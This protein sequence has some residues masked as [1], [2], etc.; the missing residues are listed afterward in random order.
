[1]M[2]SLFFQ[3]GEMLPH[4]ITQSPP[5]A[6]W[7]LAERTWQV[8]HGYNPHI[9]LCCSTQNL[10]CKVWIFLFSIRLYQVDFTKKTLHGFKNVPVFKCENKTMLSHT[11]TQQGSPKIYQYLTPASP[12]SSS[13]QT[14]S[15]VCSNSLLCNSDQTAASS[16]TGHPET[17][18]PPRA[19]T[20]HQL[21]LL[22][23]TVVVSAPKTTEHS[24]FCDARCPL[25]D[26]NTCQ[27]LRKGVK[28]Q[29]LGI[30]YPVT[31]AMTHF[32]FTMRKQFYSIDCVSMMQAVKA[33]TI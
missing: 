33:L 17:H 10:L 12:T 8:F 11:P 22:L 3:C 27:D 4:T 14:N 9:W 32:P 15:K 13:R 2:K 20:H 23:S 31:A 1:M 26:R 5:G 7:H 19:H 28:S 25:C 16:S 21:H 18:T 6:F 29:N 30:N 24:S